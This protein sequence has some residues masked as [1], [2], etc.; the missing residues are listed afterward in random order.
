MSSKFEV[1]WEDDDGS[2]DKEFSQ[3][4]SQEVREFEELMNET[5]ATE[6]KNHFVG[7]KVKA[8]VTHLSAD[9]NDVILELGGK[10]SCVMV[11]MELLDTNGD[12][13]HQVG[14]EIEAYIVSKKNGE[15]VLSFSMGQGVANEEA[16]ELAYES[17]LPVKGKVI[18]ENKGG[19][20][21][22]ILGKNG[23]CPVSQMDLKFVEDK[24]VYLNKEFDFIITKLEKRNV[25]LSRSELLKRIQ[26]EM[27][28][29]IKSKLHEN[30]ILEGTVEDIRPF[31]LMVD[32]GGV[33]GMVHISEASHS[34]LVNLHD[35]FKIEK[36]VK[37]KILSIGNEEPIPRIALS[38]KQVE[39]DPWDTISEKV[40]VSEDVTGEIVRLEAFGAFVELS[41]GIEGLIHVSEMSW[42]QKVRHPKDIL[43][44]GDKVKVRVL[45][46]DALSK[47]ISLTMKSIED[48]PWL[49]IGSH[50]KENSTYKA[51][52][53]SLK[54]FGA[55]CELEVG[56]SGL[57][58]MGT[59]KKAFGESFKKHVSPPKELE[60]MIARIDQNE[61]K[62]LLTLPNIE[63]EDDDDQDVKEYL[64]K[65]EVK[66]APVS[67]DT[68][69]FGELLKKSM[70]K[71]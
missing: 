34:R 42:V 21:V 4:K 60:V 65:Q 9:S 35:D 18:K 28:A 56:L 66:E 67:K 47:R 22:A 30:M 38:I 54:G 32:I 13:K 37:V 55:I 15:Y 46:I 71:K 26:K 20:E 29:D 36:K 57:L 50:Y 27:L 62:I 7:D 25:V 58:P 48:D 23:F 53:Q 3:K 5:N 43:K 11:K 16:L 70:N 12:L 63:S 51:S 8:M 24:S 19:F 31:G 39:G 69:S 14:D 17:K 2:F 59:I 1:N 10:V 33:T 6:V 61:K 45:S 44:T 49:K 52:V 40:N 64:Q 68:G 41:P